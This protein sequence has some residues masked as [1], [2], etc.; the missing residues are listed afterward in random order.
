MTTNVISEFRS[1]LADTA[2]GAFN[3]AICLQEMKDKGLSVPVLDVVQKGTIIHTYL[4][5]QATAADKTGVEE[6]I[7]A[8]Q[9]AVFSILPLSSTTETE[10]EDDTGGVI[11]AEALDTGALSAGAYVFIWHLT[12]WID[13]AASGVD[14]L[15]MKLMV[16]MNG[17]T[18]ARRGIAQA[19][20]VNP[21]TLSGS[22][23]LVIKDGQSVQMQL[24]FQRING[25]GAVKV[26]SARLAII[27]VPV[28]E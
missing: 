9:G 22:F 16:G 26:D 27:K 5:G 12:G 23:P 7:A 10:Q 24:T 6:V 20:T 11:E 28:S 13:P 4:N 2:T 18:K 19:T 8:H 3:R 17:G 15:E 14:R 25:S 1:P 21:E